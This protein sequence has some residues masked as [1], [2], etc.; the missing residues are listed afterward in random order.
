[1]NAAA[2]N[3]ETLISLVILIGVMVWV[4]LDAKA[5]GSDSGT[6]PGLVKTQPGWW[7]VGIFLMLILVLPA[8]LFC[9]VR[10]KRLLWERKAEAG[11]FLPTASGA[12]AET[13]GVWPPPPNIPA[14]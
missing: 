14:A 13:P 11:A 7:A 5:I 9:R 10:Y 3:I 8:Y 1:M 6:S 2:S 12:V 4:F